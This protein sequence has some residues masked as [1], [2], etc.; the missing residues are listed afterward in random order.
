MP[1]ENVPVL[2]AE[3][4]RLYWQTTRPA[5]R[6]ADELGISRSKFYALIE[7]L[8]LT[9]KCPA[10]G[11]FLAFSSRTDRE[12]ARGRCPHCGYETQVAPEDMPSVEAEAEAEAGPPPGPTEAPAP[13]HAPE[14]V[15]GLENRQLWLSALGGVAMGLLAGALWRKR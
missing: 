2:A 12:A 3:A 7:P 10:C 13:V 9:A 14:L 8:P 11:S 4:N 1:D 6:L 15:T 5:G